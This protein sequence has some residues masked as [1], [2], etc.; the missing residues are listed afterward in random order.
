LKP[1]LFK[2]RNHIPLKKNHIGYGDSA[3][4]CLKEAIKSY[5]LPGDKAIPSRD[6]F[7]QGPIAECDA[8]MNTSQRQD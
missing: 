5:G 7:T 1:L 6:D 3:T 4:G 8:E 2:I